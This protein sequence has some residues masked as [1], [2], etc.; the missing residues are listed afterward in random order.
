MARDR[1]AVP[2]AFTV[3]HEE[4]IRFHRA[5][6]SGEDLRRLDAGHGYG[7]KLFLRAVWWPTFGNLRYLIPEMPVPDLGGRRR[8]VDFAYIRNGRVS[9]SRSTDTA[10]TPVST[11]GSFPTS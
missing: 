4:F 2:D 5:Q 1:A 7:E 10:R 11:A 6:R 3:A 9:R 8:Y